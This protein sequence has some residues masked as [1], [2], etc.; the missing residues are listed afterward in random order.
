[1]QLH[2]DIAFVPKTRLSIMYEKKNI[3]IE[4]KRC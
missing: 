3:T 2:M 4:K 1:M